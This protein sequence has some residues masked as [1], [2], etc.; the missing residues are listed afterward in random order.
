VGRCGWPTTAQLALLRSLGHLLINHCRV[1][2]VG[3]PGLLAVTSTVQ[4]AVGVLRILYFLASAVAAAGQLEEATQA[5][6]VGLGCGWVR[7]RQR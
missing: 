4:G 2:A 3:N 6:E 7:G 1:W 5:A